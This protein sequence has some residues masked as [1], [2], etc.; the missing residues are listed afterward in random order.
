MSGFLK[1]KRGVSGI[2]AGIFMLL[3]FILII[4]TQIMVH[5][6]QR[7]YDEAITEKNQREWERYNEKIEIALANIDVTTL[8]ITINNN[9]AV[10]A[11]LVDLW[12]RCYGDTPPENAL[13]QKLYEIDYYVNP[14]YSISFTPP[15][16][17][18]ES[19][20]YSLK[21]VTELGNM[22]T[23]EVPYPPLYSNGGG[24]GEGS[25]QTVPMVVT[26]TQDSFQFRTTQLSIWTPAWEIWLDS[27]HGDVVFRVNVTNVWYEGKDIEIQE[28]SVTNIGQIGNEFSEKE[29]FIVAPESYPGDVSSFTTQTIPYGEWRYVYFGA[30]QVSG[31]SLE[32]LPSP[33]E[34]YI[35]FINLRFNFEG[36]SVTY[37]HTIAVMHMQINQGEMP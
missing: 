12:I 30:N 16:S 22:V 20:E 27:L 33:N 5:Q 24:M 32:P 10:V 8:T 37:G 15:G 14:G 13:W 6:Q 25:S 9:G 11:H 19:L 1:N 36:E 17:F 31:D 2:I 34:S 7:S 29:Y 21:V 26:W 35:V 3:V 18:D 28:F 4:A 23:S